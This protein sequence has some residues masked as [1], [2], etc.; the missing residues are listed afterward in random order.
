MEELV[1]EA[2]VSLRLVRRLRLRMVPAHASGAV[3]LGKYC[4]G[5]LSQAAHQDRNLGE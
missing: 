4:D 2:S 1:D 5:S 3:C